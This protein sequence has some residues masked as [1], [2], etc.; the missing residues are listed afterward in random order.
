MCYS[1]QIWDDFTKYARFGGKLNIKEFAK[2]VGWTKQKG[3]W[4]K[5]VPK[6]MRSAITD[7]ASGTLDVETIS[8]ARAADTEA[9]ALIASEI[10]VQEARLVEANAKLASPKPTKKAE[11]DA[12]VVPRSSHLRR[13]FV[14]DGGERVH[15]WIFHGTVT[16]EAPPARLRIAKVGTAS[17]SGASM[18]ASWECGNASG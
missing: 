13:R 6:A 18:S 12:A 4:I 14:G 10:G 16:L 15:G 8:A 7:A 2:L 1:A 17:R 11:N 3:S 9:I 5:V